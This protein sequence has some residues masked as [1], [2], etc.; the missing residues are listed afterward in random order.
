MHQPARTTQAGAQAGGDAPQR[1]LHIEDSETDAFIVRRALRGL[2]SLTIDWVATGAEGIEHAERNAY[3]L[4]LLDY[5]LPDM[6]GIEVLVRLQDK[7]PQ[8]PVVMVSGF[9]SEYVAARGIHLG[10]IGF[11]NKDSPEFKDRL[12][13]S[14]RKL[15]SQGLEHRR[16]RAVQ[17]RAREEPSFRQAIESVLSDLCDVI[18]AARGA[19]VASM[20]GFPIAVS[21]HGQE[22]DIDVLSAMATASVLKNLDVVGNSFSLAAHRGGLLFFEKGSMLFHK[23]ENVGSLVVVLDRQAAWQEDGLELEQAVKEVEQVVLG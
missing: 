18:P 5:A 20:D 14:V 1:I 13:D 22:R 2:P 9:G 21:H 15:W 16:A 3:D 17:D 11:L 23:L 7:A 6:T 4:I 10:A 12:A 8:S 19:F